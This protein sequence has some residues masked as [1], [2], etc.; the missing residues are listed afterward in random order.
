MPDHIKL[1]CII[2]V[3]N[4]KTLAENVPWRALI[5]NPSEQIFCHKGN[6]WC[7][8]QLFYIY[9]VPLVKHGLWH[10][11]LNWLR[12]YYLVGTRSDASQ[13]VKIS[14]I[15]QSLTVPTPHHMIP[16][17][18]YLKS[19]RC[20]SAAYFSGSGLSTLACSQIMGSTPV[21]KKT[22]VS[23]VNHTHKKPN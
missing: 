16:M 4:H 18:I 12:L 23:E 17:A 11:S 21:W 1:R 9:Y 7:K 3:V 20:S 5:W 15:H 13:N 22:T 19:D 8:T 6:K 2:H 10:Y 14:N